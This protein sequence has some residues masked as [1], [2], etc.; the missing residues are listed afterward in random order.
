[1]SPIR[2]SLVVALLCVAA[3]AY[4][5]A[6]PSSADGVSASAEHVE[7]GVPIAKLI[8]AVAKKTGKKFVVDPRVHAEVSLMGQDPANVSYNDLLT[9]LEMY[10]YVAAEFGGYVNVSPISN[11]RQEPSPLLTGKDSRPDAEVVTTVIT[12]KSVPAAH[13]VPIL[14]PLIPQYGHL[15]ALPCANKLILVDTFGN[16]KRLKAVIESMDVGEPYKPEKCEPRSPERS[17]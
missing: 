4:P 12:L 14:R 8:A 2:L 13:L 15:A 5:Q 1:M 7:N 11:A 10:G 3:I 9:I 17:S 16:V 6:S